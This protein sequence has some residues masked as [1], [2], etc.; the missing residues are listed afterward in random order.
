MV[1]RTK[2]TV[3]VYDVTQLE[4]ICRHDDWEVMTIQGHLTMEK[5]ESAHLELLSHTAARRYS[6]RKKRSTDRVEGEKVLNSIRYKVEY[7]FHRFK[8]RFGYRK[9]R[10]RRLTKNTAA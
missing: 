6:Q 5:R 8:F 2:G 4:E 3:I 9:F 1:P 10:Y 7:T